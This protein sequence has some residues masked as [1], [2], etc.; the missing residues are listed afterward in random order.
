MWI[1]THHYLAGIVHKYIEER[2]GVNIKLDMLQYG[3]V[4]PD[5]FWEYVKIPHYYPDSLPF[6]TEELKNIIIDKKFNNLREFSIKLGV[7]LH[8]T[9]DYLCYAHNN[10]HYKSNL[11]SHF[12]YEINLHH[13][14]H[15]YKCKGISIPAYK[16][17][18]AMI[19]ALRNKYLETEPSMEK[20][21]E[22]ITA[23][24]LRLAEMLIEAVLLPAVSV[25]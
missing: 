12:N 11:W 19:A 1:Q 10:E 8:F 9:A 17:P 3:S 6:F 25:A 18:H 20:D 15:H 22:Y 14:F 23:A 24:S 5:F 21:V 2:Y 16:S 13:C 7:L 4:K